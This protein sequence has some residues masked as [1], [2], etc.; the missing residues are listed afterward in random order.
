[1]LTWHDSCLGG[2]LR[3][4]LR[5][6]LR[7]NQAGNLFPIPGHL[8]EQNRH[9]F[10]RQRPPCIHLSGERGEDPRIHT[11]ETD[12]VEIV[13]FSSGLLVLGLA[14]VNLHECPRGPRGVLAELSLDVL[15]DRVL[16]RG[17]TIQ[18]ILEGVNNFCTDFP[19]FFRMRKP[20]SLKDLH[21]AGEA[22]AS[23]FD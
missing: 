4:D 22:I 3:R 18:E 5:Q 9:L 15:F 20:L 13:G 19:T 6:L 23:K 21:K 2:D 11:V 7:G 8:S 12:S 17:N 16:H 1:M 14:F 10:R